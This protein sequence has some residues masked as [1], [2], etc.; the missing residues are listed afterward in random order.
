M[1]SLF[2]LG[3]FMVGFCLA[4]GMVGFFVRLLRVVVLGLFLLGTSAF[5]NDSVRTIWNNHCSYQ[6]TG[7][8]F[9]NDATGLTFTSSSGQVPGNG[10]TELYFTV[11]ATESQGVMAY[12]TTYRALAG[13]NVGWLTCVPAGVTLYK[14]AVPQ[15]EIYPPGGAPVTNTGCI[16]LRN[17]S[18]SVRYYQF[19]RSYGS[20]V[21]QLGAD[22]SSLTFTGP[23]YPGGPSLSGVGLTGAAGDGKWMAVYPGEDITVCTSFSGA[24][25]QFWNLCAVTSGS[26]DVA[27]Y[28]TVAQRFYK[29]SYDG[30]GVAFPPGDSENA[31]CVQLSQ[32]GGTTGLA[33]NTTT[34]SQS[35]SN[36]VGTN[37]ITFSGVAGA[38]LDST[39]QTGFSAE[40]N[41]LNRLHS[42][43]VGLS[44]L[45][46]SEGSAIVGAV[47][48]SGGGG[49]STNSSSGGLVG[50]TNFPT[51]YPD[52]AANSNLLGMPSNL[53]AALS[54]YSVGISNRY[55]G[56]SISNTAYL[57]NIGYSAG[58]AMAGEFSNLVGP[59]PNV[60][61][62]GQGSVDGSTIQLGEYV[63]SGQPI[64][65]TIG[66]SG[67][68]AEVQGWLSSI[69]AIIAWL[70][71]GFT[72]VKI[73]DYCKEAIWRCFQVQQVHG[74]QQEAVG[75]NL[76]FVTGILYSGVILSVVMSVP[77][78]ASAVLET[79]RGN[80]QQGFSLIARVTGDDPM[81]TLLGN[82]FPLETLLTAIVDAIAVRL[83]FL[84]SGELIAASVIKYMV[85]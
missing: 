62:L 5:G 19:N 70:I 26:L 50:V 37:G 71:A 61:P 47:K 25:N 49:G 60:L 65:F 78:F 39:A 76:S 64:N 82:V 36:W 59:I 27:G 53:V 22:D 4:F 14:G 31:G 69:K 9:S 57:S 3:V 17:D 85:T 81:W 66:W 8:L 72:F 29:M 6:T 38:A 83:V 21:V 13:A 43:N 54:N 56:A 40:Y 75:T 80:A 58:A 23:G 63:A 7:I 11:G 20:T 10:G 51:N 55:G 24:S 32:V 48:S 46:G 1:T 44:A 45:I 16:E 79:Y 73:L 42:D 28:S 2:L 18:T 35:S 77:V 30:A 67:L 34:N 52:S 15:I 33:S 12:G 74:S 68:G 41:A 84:T